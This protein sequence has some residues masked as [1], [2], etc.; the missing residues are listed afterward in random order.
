MITRG[1][2]PTSGSLIPPR[3]IKYSVLYIASLVALDQI[4]V[5]TDA[6]IVLLAV[7]A[8]ALVFLGGLA[9]KDFLASGAAGIYLLLNQ[10][11]GIGDDVRIGDHR[12]IVQEVDVFVTH[13]ENDEE[14]FIVPNSRVLES[15]IVRIRS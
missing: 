13:I 11:Y 9:F 12:G 4:G 10:P 1:R 15:G 5:N 7:Y 14:E 6:L 2:I 8:F 3:V